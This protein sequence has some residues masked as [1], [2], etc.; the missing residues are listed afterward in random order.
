MRCR[1]ILKRAECQDTIAVYVRMYAPGFRYSYAVDIVIAYDL[2]FIY[3][4]LVKREI[5]DDVKPV[6]RHCVSALSSIQRSVDSR[7]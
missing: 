3:W 7:V 5:F 1:L 2:K 4:N 6:M